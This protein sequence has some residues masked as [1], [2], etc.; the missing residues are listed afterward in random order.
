VLFL[1]RKS[2]RLVTTFTALSRENWQIAET[3]SMQM[4]R[5]NAVDAYVL[6]KQTRFRFPSWHTRRLSLVHFIRIKALHANVLSRFRS[7]SVRFKLAVIF[8]KL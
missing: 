3:P 2:S 8:G 5:I 1:R 4:N 7:N 6:Y